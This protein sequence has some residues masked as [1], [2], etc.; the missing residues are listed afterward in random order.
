LITFIVSTASTFD[1]QGV[2]GNQVYFDSLTM[3]VFFLLASRWLEVKMRNTTA[4]SLEVLTRRMPAWVERQNA[5]GVFERIA[6]KDL[7]VVS[8]YDLWQGLVQDKAPW[9]VSTIAT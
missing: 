1:D 3:F 8:A 5:L 2:F 4:G 6:T 7:K 9:C